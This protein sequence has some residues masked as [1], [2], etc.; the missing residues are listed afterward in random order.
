M[1]SGKRLA[2]CRGLPRRLTASVVISCLATASAGTPR[3]RRCGGSRAAAPPPRSRRRPAARR[4]CGPRPSP[5]SGRR[6]PAPRAGRTRRRAAP[7]RASASAAQ[8]PVDLG[9]R[10]DIDAARRL[11]DDQELRLHRQPLREQHLLLVAAR[12]IADQ[13]ARRS[14]SRSAARRRSCS[15]SAS[16]L[17]SE[18]FAP[19]ETLRSTVAATLSTMSMPRNSPPPCGPRAPCRCRPP[20]RPT[21]PA[22]RSRG[23]S[24][25]R[26]RPARPG[27]E[28]RLAELACAPS[29]SARRGRRSRPPAP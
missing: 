18:K 5:R 6:A 22:A 21:G 15:A 12:E 24:T 4:R 11:V 28:D 19:D 25:R 7:R 20:C 13:L 23:P 26:C 2:P 8:Q 3:P 17:G 14:A 10:A 16:A 27:A 1:R 9:A 29:R